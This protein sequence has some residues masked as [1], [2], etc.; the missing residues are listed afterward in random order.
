MVA[1]A[2]WSAAD[3][4]NPRGCDATKQD[5]RTSNTTQRRQGPEQPLKPMLASRSLERHL[6]KQ[7]P[8][9]T[10][11]RVQMQALISQWSETNIQETMPNPTAAGTSSTYTDGG[12]RGALHMVRLGGLAAGTRY[13]YRASYAGVH[14]AETFDFRAPRTGAPTT[15]AP[16]VVSCTV[17]Q[18]S[19]VRAAKSLSKQNVATSGEGALPLSVP[20]GSMHW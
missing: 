17:M 1:L 10:S 7:M 2:V 16:L 20:G 19:S 12:W 11:M 18:P 3:W 6:A 8:M 9:K 14:A 13:Y 15:T 4:S 5:Q